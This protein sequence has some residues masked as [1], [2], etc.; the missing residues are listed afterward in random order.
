M[1][2]LSRAA[3]SAVLAGLLLASTA[4]SGSPSQAP[5]ATPLPADHQAV[6]MNGL[7]VTVDDVSP[8]RVNTDGSQQYVATYTVSNPRV[9]PLVFPKKEQVLF[10]D[11]KQYPADTEATAA[12]SNS[13]LLLVLNSGATQQSK[14]VFNLPAGAKVTGAGVYVNFSL[15]RVNLAS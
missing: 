2:A 7:D 10:A 1:S 13:G 11:G 4:C 14:V 3:F 8:I 6:R 15:W 5:V 9:E 12:I